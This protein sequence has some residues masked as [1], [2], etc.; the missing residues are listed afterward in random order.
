MA[1]EIVE[2]VLGPPRVRE[3][4]RIVGREFVK[5]F[6]AQTMEASQIEATGRYCA[7]W[8]A[9]ITTSKK[10][11]EILKEH[12]PDIWE[13]HFNGSSDHENNEHH[14]SGSEDS[15][16]DVQENRGLADQKASVGEVHASSEDRSE[17][18]VSNG[19]SEST[20]A[21]VGTKEPEADHNDKLM[22]ALLSLDPENDE[23]WNKDC[24]PAMAAIENE[25]GAA[26]VTRAQVED[27]WPDFDR[28]V[29]R[30]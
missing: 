16:G 8:N 20:E 7:G 11:Q 19:N 24:R 25:Y 30:E 1:A 14:S 4:V 9:H 12:Y 15:V 26:D 29:A 18:S 6:F 22:N 21:E 2:F 23:H 28:N 13:E 17:G 27:L 5:G 10:G 3:S